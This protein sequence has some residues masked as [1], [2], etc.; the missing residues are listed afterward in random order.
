MVRFKGSLLQAGFAVAVAFGVAGL[1]GAGS[2]G[3]QVKEFSLANTNPPKHGT[4][5][6]AQAFIDK[7]GELTGGKMKVI[8]HHSGALGGEREAAQQ[9]QL[10]AVDFGPITTAP[11]SGLVPELSV[12]QLPYIFRDYDHVYKA[13]DGSDKLQNYYAG[14]LDKRGFHLIGFIVAGYRGIYGHGKIEKLADIKGKKVRVQEDKI[15]V[16]TF[17]ALGAIP[18]PIAWPEVATSLQ[19]KVID[20]AEGGVNTFYHNKFYDL[21]KYVADVRHTHQCIALVM[22]K[23]SWSKLDAAGQ[24]AIGDAWV[25]ARA[26]NRKFIIDEDKSIQDQ[27]RAKGVTITKP[28]PAPFLPR[29]RAST[30]T[31]T[32]PCRQECTTD[33]GVHPEHQVD[34][35]GQSIRAASRPQLRTARGPSA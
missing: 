29:P 20:F 33:G 13:L 12:F 27:V 7:L 34:A 35:D 15:L 26:Y 8:H 19:T 11:L 25:H 10:G 21:V 6:A 22:S 18:T 23:A 31:S 16:A 24:K 32:R 3:A 9:I 14:V 5:K 30:T 17:K 4:S 1:A 2:A 28:D